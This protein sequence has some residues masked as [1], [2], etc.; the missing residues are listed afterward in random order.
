M[1]ENEQ[2]IVRVVLGNQAEI[3]NALSVLCRE[4]Q[5]VT[6]AEELRRRAGDTRDF[7]KRVVPLPGER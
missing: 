7:K 4:R 5:L 3:L 1:T 6:I 2:D